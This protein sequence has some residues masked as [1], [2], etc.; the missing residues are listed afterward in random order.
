[1]ELKKRVFSQKSYD[2][3]I[4]LIGYGRMGHE[5]EEMA[6]RRGHSIKLIIDIDNRHDFVEEKF[7][8][9]DAVIEFT[10]PESAFNNISKCLRMKK[11]VVSGTTGWLNDYGKAVELCS[12]NATSFIH[13][14]NFSVGVHILFR[15][16]SELASMM[17][18]LNEY[19]VSIEEIHHVKKLDAPSGTAISLADGI[20]KKHKGYNGWSFP[21]KVSD[22]RI[23]IRSVREGTVPGTHTVEWNSDIDIISLRHEA[24][25]RKGLALG[26]VLA[27]E[28]IALRKGV[29]TMNDVLGF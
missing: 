20:I 27:A 4:A 17:D 22:D 24:M 5:I 15:L 28:Y 12:K 10:V 21:D 9:I 18:K 19:K 25:G 14:S 1:M 13:S 26:A 16:N 11:P 8:E 3:N 6:L 29:F 2:M 7:R 23:P